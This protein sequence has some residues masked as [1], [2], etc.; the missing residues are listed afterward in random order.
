MQPWPVFPDATALTPLRAHAPHGRSGPAAA[1]AELVAGNGRVAAGAPRHGREVGITRSGQVAP[2][3][4]V[5][6]CI[7][8]R[9]PVEAIFDVEVG[10]VCVARSAGH[11]LDRALTGSIEFA[12]VNLGVHLVVVLGHQRCAA[13][14]AA[15]EAASAGRRDPGGGGYVIDQILPVV[16]RGGAGADKL[17]QT[18]R[19]HVRNTVTAL[20]RLPPLTEAV[21]QGRL[22]IVGAVYQ[23]DNAQVLLLS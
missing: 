17:D 18:I 3:A 16:D 10:S 14:A 8:A 6:G 12:V 1:L 9:V 13:V 11:V 2:Q 20:R 15:V 22:D 21:R 7:D 4:L 5:L 19:A 23:L